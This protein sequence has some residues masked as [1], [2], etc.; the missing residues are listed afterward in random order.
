MQ[1]ESGGEFGPK[2]LLF[3]PQSEDAAAE[4]SYQALVIPGDSFDRAH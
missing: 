3:L 4:G 1:G 2:E